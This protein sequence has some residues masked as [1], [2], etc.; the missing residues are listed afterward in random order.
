MFAETKSKIF[1]ESQVLKDRVEIQERVEEE[2]NY[3]RKM[4]TLRRMLKECPTMRA[5]QQEFND[6]RKQTLKLIKAVNDERKNHY[7]DDITKIPTH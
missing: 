7:K 3:S 6:R 2:K 4:S 5:N 1:S